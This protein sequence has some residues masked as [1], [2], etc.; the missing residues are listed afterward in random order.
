MNKKQSRR[1]ASERVRGILADLADAIC[2]TQNK[3]TLSMQGNTF[4]INL[5]G[6]SINITINEKGGEA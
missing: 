5:E 3:V 2:E 1:V 4:E 6:A